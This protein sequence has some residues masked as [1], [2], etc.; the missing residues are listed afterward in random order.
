VFGERVVERRHQAGMS[1]MELADRIGAHF[2]WVSR[3]ERGVRD[4]R[5][6]NVVRIAAGL[7]VDPADLV[8]GLKPDK[9]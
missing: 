4:P 7:G 6:S 5:L 1:Q 9:E 8:R 3:I 2:T